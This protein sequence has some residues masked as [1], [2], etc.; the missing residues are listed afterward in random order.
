M[1]DESA[2]RAV[3]RLVI[4]VMVEHARQLGQRNQAAMDDGA[5]ENLSLRTAQ[6]QQVSCR[7]ASAEA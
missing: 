3:C 7:L 1:Q 6:A 5:Q 4:Q 2:P